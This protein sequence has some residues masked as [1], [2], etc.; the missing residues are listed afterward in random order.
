MDGVEGKGLARRRTPV[1]MRP[2]TAHWD[3]APPKQ[4]ANP[5][6]N[7]GGWV[8]QAALV[9][10]QGPLRYSKGPSLARK[11]GNGSR[12]QAADQ[13]LPKHHLTVIP[14]LNFR[15]IRHWSLSAINLS[16]PAWP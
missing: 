5:G 1:P 16:K 9:G 3:R 8:A 6:W 15:R 14:I 12:E 13:A 7:P 10:K 4:K 2:R 11:L